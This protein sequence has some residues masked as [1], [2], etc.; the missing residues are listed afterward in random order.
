M[1]SYGE[2]IRTLNED[3]T[4]RKKKGKLPND[5]TSKLK[6][7]WSEN[8][9]WPYPSVSLSTRKLRRTNIPDCNTVVT[10][11]MCSTQTFA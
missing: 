4:S 3:F 1:F 10:L 11:R 7:W 9:V 6:Q 8:L 2:A 5:A